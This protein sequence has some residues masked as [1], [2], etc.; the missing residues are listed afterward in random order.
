M[1]YR[2]FIKLK[3]KILIL[4]IGGKE[5]NWE[6]SACDRLFGG[7]ETIAIICHLKI[8]TSFVS[9]LEIRARHSVSIRDLVK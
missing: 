6:E 2:S 3:K 4:H 7:I 8:G 1:I 5:K 9:C